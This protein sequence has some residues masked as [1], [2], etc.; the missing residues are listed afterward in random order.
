MQPK[1]YYAI[2]KINKYFPLNYTS[3]KLFSLEYLFLND[4]IDI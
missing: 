1:K 2:D 3:V 4:K